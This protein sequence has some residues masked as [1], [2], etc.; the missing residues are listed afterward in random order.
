MNG[1][2]TIVKNVTGITSL[3]SATSEASNYPF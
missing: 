2:V 3:I 1:Y